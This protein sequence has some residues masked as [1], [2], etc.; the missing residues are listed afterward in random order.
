MLILAY[1]E[2]P[3]GS[4]DTPGAR[5]QDKTSTSFP[6]F[7]IKQLSIQTILIFENNNQDSGL[8]AK[9]A[10]DSQYCILRTYP[11]GLISA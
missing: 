9:M 6:A 7:H 10:S 11:M 8:Q 3:S 2:G 5:A 4:N 1:A